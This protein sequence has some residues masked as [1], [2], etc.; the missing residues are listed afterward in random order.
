MEFRKL[1]EERRSVNYFDPAGQVSD[2]ELKKMVALASLVP[3][4]FN[5]Q[6][7]N[8]IVLRSPID[9]ARLRKV[10]M[11]QPKITEAPVVLILLADEEGYKENNPTVG[12]VWE[13]MEKKGYMKPEQKGWF[14]GA[15]SK[16][17]GGDNSLAFAVKNTAFFGMGLML[18]A[19][20][21]GLD[22]HPMDGFSREGVMK[23]FSIPANFF[24]PMLL[25]VG[26]FDQSK[27]LLERNWRKSYR[28]I[29]I[30]EL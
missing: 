2:E 24:V 12:K 4:S 22:S 14:L 9:K 3:S 15:I 6:P 29:V 28:E 26:R 11:D 13:S 1:M 30:S 27:K 18:A 20:E 16:L 21:L 17:Y 10:A 19:K 8:M 5:L 7:W 25:A 23:E